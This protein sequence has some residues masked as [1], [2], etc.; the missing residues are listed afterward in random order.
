MTLFPSAHKEVKENISAKIS[1]K[2]K[3][4]GKSSYLCMHLLQSY[5]HGIRGNRHLL[6]VSYK[7]VSPSFLSSNGAGLMLSLN[8]TIGVVWSLNVSL[9][10]LMVISL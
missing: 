8:S 9:G 5:G 3:T 4:S 1:E 7:K 10:M 6:Q 2:T